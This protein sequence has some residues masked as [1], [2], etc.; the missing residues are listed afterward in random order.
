MPHVG[1]RRRCARRK[2]PLARWIVPLALVLDGHVASGLE[3]ATPA[4]PCRDMFPQWSPD[5]ERIVFTS[6]R[7]GDPEIY[8]MNADGSDPV[9]LTHAT[10]RDAHPCFARDGQRIVFQSPRANER[11]A[12]W[13]PDGKRLL[14]SSEGDGW[15]RI[16]VMDRDGSGMVCLSEAG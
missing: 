10:G 14:F 5:G 3:E 8:L 7:D 9:R 4:P 2:L 11:G 13:S 16:Y 1:A 12:A 15:S 6:D